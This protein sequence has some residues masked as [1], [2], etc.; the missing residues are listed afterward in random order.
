MNR[1]QEFN[2]IMKS[3]MAFQRHETEAFYKVAVKF[4]A[5]DEDLAKEA[6]VSKQ[7]I[8]QKYKHLKV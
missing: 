1:A 8:E 5:K 7:A 6:G 2:Q 4:G 3:W